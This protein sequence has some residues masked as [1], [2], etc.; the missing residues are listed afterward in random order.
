MYVD[1]LIDITTA[2]LVLVVVRIPDC[3][4]PAINSRL[5]ADTGANVNS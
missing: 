2:A 3:I 4:S 1:A 5:V